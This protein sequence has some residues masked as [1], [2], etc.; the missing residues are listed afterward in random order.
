[1]YTRQ[2]RAT[3]N[4]LPSNTPSTKVDTTRTRTTSKTSHKYANNPDYEYDITSNRWRK[5]S[6]I[7]PLKLVNRY[8]AF[9]LDHLTTISNKNQKEIEKIVRKHATSTRRLENILVDK[10]IMTAQEAY[11]FLFDN[12]FWQKELCNHMKKVCPTETDLSGEDWCSYSEEALLY[13][14]DPKTKIISCFSSTDLVSIISNSFTGEEN[15]NVFLQLP[16][17]PY[18]R[19]VLPETHIKKMLKLLRPDEETLSKLAYPHVI[20]FLRHYKRFYKDPT[21]KPFLTKSMLT[22]KEKLELSEAIEDFLL[23]TDEIRN[24]LSKSGK[25]WWFWK[26]G[27]KPTNIHKYIFHDTNTK[28][29]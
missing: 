17:D 21:I 24:N 14:K 8:K 1:M 29:A 7:R 2:M 5:K 27:K 16:R 4:V 18:T 6:D 20:Y 19:K 12:D 28:E 11:D 10:G 15:G 25:Q 13:H 26:S 9:L 3:P 22:K 23:E